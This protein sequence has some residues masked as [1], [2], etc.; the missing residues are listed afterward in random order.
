MKAN[1][2]SA[3]VHGRENG[4]V[5][6]LNTDWGDKGH[7]QYQPISYA[8]YVYGA[9]LSWNIQNNRDM[10]IGVYLDEF[11][12][13]DKKK[14]T[15]QNI[16]DMGNYY[17]LENSKIFNRTLISKILNSDLDDM[18][19]L[20]GFDESVFANIGIYIE[21]IMKRLDFAEMHSPDAVL[22][23]GELR[24]TCRI[25]LH[26][27][28]L[29]KLKILLKSEVSHGLID[30]IAA[31]M[32]SDMDEIMENHRKLWLARNRAGGLEESLKGMRHLEERY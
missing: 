20:E 21:E 3:A 31:D 4:A 22:V 14:V 30:E 7:W 15:T 1:L 10:D 25:V 16:L 27:A 23:D 32:I 18:K 11:V 12:F 24:N 28:K 17:L 29:A 8:S 6:F 26:G 2:V 13:M 19:P 9:G 5:G